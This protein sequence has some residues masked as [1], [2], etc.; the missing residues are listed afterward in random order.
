VSV[1]DL[2]EI[3][4]EQLA[5]LPLSEKLQMR[6]SL[7][8]RMEQL[9]RAL[10]SHAR[11]CD[12]DSLSSSDMPPP[13]AEPPAIALPAVGLRWGDTFKN[14]LNEV[15]AAEAEGVLKEC[16]IVSVDD[17]VKIKLWQLAHWFGNTSKCP[18]L[19]V[20]LAR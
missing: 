20:K 10:E 8:I 14:F 12:A 9:R 19:I 17:L 15:G 16:G 3:N 1:D 2:V 5:S 18:T 13:S 7:G 11:T 4:D 6:L